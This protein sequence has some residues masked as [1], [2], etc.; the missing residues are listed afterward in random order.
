MDLEVAAVDP[1]VVGDDHRGELDILVGDR[2]LRAVQLGDDQVQAAEHL[3]LELDEVLAELV[4]RLTHQ[5]VRTFP[6]TLGVSTFC[7]ILTVS[8]P[9]DRAVGTLAAD[10]APAAFV[11]GSEATLETIGTSVAAHAS[12]WLHAPPG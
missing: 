4:P 8:D 3:M 2:L 9:R 5:I 6:L 11:D 10:L 7:S 1:I 12:E